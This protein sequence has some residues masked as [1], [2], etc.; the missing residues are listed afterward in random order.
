MLQFSFLD[1]YFAL[2]KTRVKTQSVLIISSMAVAS[3]FG[4]GQ[5]ETCSKSK[6]TQYEQIPVFPESSS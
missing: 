2:I 1:A 3:T 5:Q 6:H 4:S